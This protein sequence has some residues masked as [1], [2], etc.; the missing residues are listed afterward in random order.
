[1]VNCLKPLGRP[2][3]DLR[4]CKWRALQRIDGVTNSWIASQ[5]TIFMTNLIPDPASPTRLTVKIPAELKFS[6]PTC[7]ACTKFLA[8][9]QSASCF[10]ANFSPV[11]KEWEIPARPMKLRVLEIY[12]DSI[13]WVVFSFLTKRSSGFSCTTLKL[14]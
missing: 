1:M 2:L 12:S 6:K 3:P 4:C 13:D 7:D 8:S 5:V 11:P 14:G 10:N 9:G